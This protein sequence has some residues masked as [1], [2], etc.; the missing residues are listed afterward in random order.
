[1]RT[2]QSAARRG[3]EPL[4]HLLGLVGWVLL[5]D[6]V[7]AIVRAIYFVA[8]IILVDKRVPLF[9][10]ILIVLYLA[11]SALSGWL[12][13]RWKKATGPL[14][15]RVGMRF[16]TIAYAYLVLP[17]LLV[18]DLGDL[19]S[20]LNVPASSAVL[21]VV[22][23]AIFAASVLLLGLSMFALHRERVRQT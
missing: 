16:A 23:L 1:M 17:A 19:I 21:T 10:S 6:A 5:A 9:G 14:R 4:S 12:Y 2:T 18:F 3:S 22:W 11:L 20:A 7:L 8:T 13:V 15:P